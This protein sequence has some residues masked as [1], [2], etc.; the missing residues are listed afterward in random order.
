MS[1]MCFHLLDSEV[2]D[3]CRRAAP[4][5]RA[6]FTPDEQEIMD[7][8]VAAHNKFS[9]L[10]TTHPDETR[11]WFDGVHALQD[12]IGRRILRRLFPATYPTKG[13]DVL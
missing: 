5:A 11:E 3:E 1:G 6:P 9:T 10:E 7:L 2:C 12:V 4:A 8:L 13:N